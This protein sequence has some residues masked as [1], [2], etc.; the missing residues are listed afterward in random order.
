MVQTDYDHDT[1][2]SRSFESGLNP[3]REAWSACSL[4]RTQP[5]TD[6]STTTHVRAHARLIS[7]RRGSAGP[8]D[9]GGPTPSSPQR[10]EPV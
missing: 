4:R 7:N 3:V 9:R 6:G 8:T 5:I 2:S 1:V 10:L